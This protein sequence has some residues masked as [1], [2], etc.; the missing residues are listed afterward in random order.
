MAD[1]WQLPYHPLV[2]NKSFSS[3]AADSQAFHGAGHLLADF[4]Q[5]LGIVEVGGGQHDGLGARLGFFALGSDAE[6]ERHRAALHEDARADEH[7]LG[8]H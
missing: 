6:I 7:R 2:C 4:G 8:A 3:M 1:G 5:H